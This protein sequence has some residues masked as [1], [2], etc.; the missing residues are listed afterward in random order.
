MRIVFDTNVWLDWLHFDDPVI[1]PL[2][3]ALPRSGIVLLM[4]ETC[5]EELL[6]VLAYPRFGLSVDQQTLHIG[7]VRALVLMNEVSRDS[8]RG[9]LPVCSDPDDQKF[10]ELARDAGADWLV[11]KDRALLTLMRK[12]HRLSSFKIATPVEFEAMR[13]ITLR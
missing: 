1:A 10:L 13:R 2:K 11:T 7:S 6:R 4:N 9:A 12:K 3:A 5:L 8:S